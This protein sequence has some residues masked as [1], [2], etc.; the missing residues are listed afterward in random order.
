MI[1]TYSLKTRGGQ[2]RNYP[3]GQYV[4]VAI[5]FIKKSL[6]TFFIFIGSQLLKVLNFQ[7]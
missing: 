2:F 3:V 5:K 4:D 6:I 1:D 7:I